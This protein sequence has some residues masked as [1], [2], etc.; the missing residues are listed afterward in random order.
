[1]KG[2]IYVIT[3]KAMP[4]LVEVGYSMKD[5]EIRARELYS[6]GVP[7][8]DTVEYDVLVNEPYEVVQRAHKLLKDR[9]ENTGW[10]RCDINQAVNSIREVAGNSIIH[11]SFKLSVD[12]VKKTNFDSAHETVIGK[13]FL[14]DGIATDTETWLTWLRFAYGQQWDRNKVIGNAIKMRWKDA[15]AIPTTFNQIGYA[16]YNDWR[17]PSIDELNTL[18]NKNE[19]IK[20]S[21]IDL[22]VF[23]KIPMSLWSS[24]PYN[25]VNGYE[26]PVDYNDSISYDNF[27]NSSSFVCLVRYAA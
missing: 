15:M 9:I 10:F 17:I 24:S 22:D 6:I 12:A 18:I 11:E 26:L 5:P 14:E 25:F 1:M 3:N 27:V 23:P 20:G 16:G 4:N 21:Y 2:W 19:E 13:F 7:H 8:S